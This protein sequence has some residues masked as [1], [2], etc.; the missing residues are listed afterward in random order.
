MDTEMNIVQPVDT[1]LPVDDMTNII[2]EPTGI[3]Q[4]VPLDV[5]DGVQD[6]SN[7]TIGQ[8]FGTL[9]ESITIVWRFHL[10]TNKHYYHVILNDFYNDAIDLVDAI[11]EHYQGQNGIVEDYINT[12][13]GE[14]KSEIDYL[15]ELRNFTIDSRQKL[16][17]TEWTELWSDVDDFIGLI[18]STLYKLT[19]FTENKIKTFEQ[20]C[21]E[22]YEG[23]IE[24]GADGVFDTVTKTLS[25]NVTKDSAKTKCTNCECCDDDDDDE[26]EE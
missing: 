21:F 13:L 15:K 12:I 8:F 20:F 1:S 22:D 10:Q 18:D 23:G 11:I 17:N 19:S 24:G 26:E 9:Q 14:N 2:P 3:D 25:T 4:P 5:V 6:T 7:T 16:F